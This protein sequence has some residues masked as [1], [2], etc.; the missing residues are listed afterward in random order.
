M[1][2]HFAV[3]RSQYLNLLALRLLTLLLCTALQCRILPCLIATLRTASN[4]VTL[5]VIVGA[6][7]G[8]TTILPSSRFSHLFSGTKRGR[9]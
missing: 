1:G 7:I 3:A 2:T 8:Q 5:D 4:T 6:L 9:F